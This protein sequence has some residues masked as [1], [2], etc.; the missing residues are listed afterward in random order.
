[1][2]KNAVK[3][4][5]EGETLGDV[6]MQIR[7]EIRKSPVVAPRGMNTKEIHPAMVCIHNPRSRL[8]YNK[9]R[10]FNL[11][12]ALVDSLMIF[13]RSNEVRYLSR[14]NRN[15]TQFSD[16]GKHLNSMYGQYLYDQIPPCITKLSSS[17]DTR[18]A[19][20]TIYSGD[21]L[22]KNTKDVP[23]TIALHFMIR[24]GKLDLTTYM[25][26]NDLIWGFQYDMFVFTMLQECMANTLGI[27]V[28]D[29]Y[30]VATSLHLYERDWKLLDKM[31]SVEPIQFKNELDVFEMMWLAGDFT[32][33]DILMPS[34]LHC[35]TSEIAKLIQCEQLYQIGKLK[36][37]FATQWSYKFTKRW[38][39]EAK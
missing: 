24:N 19:V 9:F 23:C 22:E 31:E 7:D 2:V 14:F 13:N 5:F 39:K 33:S 4:Y 12:Y 11:I 29:Y 16:D 32:R 8:I 34:D 1:M 17:N 36:K 21:Y 27:D 15:I 30:H 20:M 10:K 37:P 26:S 28:G 3:R 38:F 6:F 35:Q 18:Q 25:R